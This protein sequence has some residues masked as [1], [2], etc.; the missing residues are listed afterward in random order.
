[1][2]DG[3]GG[4]GPPGAREIDLS[5]MDINQLNELKQSHEQVRSLD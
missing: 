4:G 5:Q 3:G 2:A 1:M